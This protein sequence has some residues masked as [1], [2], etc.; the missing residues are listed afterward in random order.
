MPEIEMAREGM[1]HAAHEHAHGVLMCASND[2]WPASVA[3]TP[4]TKT[5]LW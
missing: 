5:C 3:Q 2:F 1:E 4:S